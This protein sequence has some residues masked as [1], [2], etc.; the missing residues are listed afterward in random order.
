MTSR[1]RTFATLFTV[2]LAATLLGALFTT[3]AGPPPPPPFGASG[4]TT[5]ASATAVPVA[6]QAADSGAALGLN[7]F[8]DIARTVNDGVVNINTAGAEQLQLLPRVGTAEIRVP[9]DSPNLVE[10]KSLKLYLGSFAMSALASA[11]D[12]AAVIRKDLSAA[13]GKDVTVAVRDPDTP[14][15]SA[16]AYGYDLAHRLTNLS[17]SNMVAGTIVAASFALQGDVNIAEPGALIGFATNRRLGI[18]AVKPGPKHF[19]PMADLCGS[20][21]VDIHVDRTFSLDEVPEALAYAGAGRALDR[22]AYGGADALGRDELLDLY[23]AAEHW[24]RRHRAPA[25]EA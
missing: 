7:T 13:A 10:S 16:V 23:G 15:G 24:L 20:G 14:D 21:E 18:L 25:R 17:D 11:R 22:L 8:R 2:A 12:L 1:T 9:A 6:R 3:H 4:R 5:T 19:T